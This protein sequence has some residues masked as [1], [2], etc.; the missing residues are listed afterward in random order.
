[1]T[2]DHLRP[3]VNALAG[4]YEAQ[5]RALAARLDL[6]ALRITTHAYGAQPHHA[7]DVIAPAAPTAPMPVVLFLHG[8][9]FTHGHR[10][11]NHFMAPAIRAAGAIL[12]SA[13][14]RLLEDGNP[15]PVPVDDV[16]TAIDWIRDNATSFGG[17]PARIFTGGHSAGAALAL[18]AA[19]RV[20]H[21]ALCGVLCLSGSLNRWAIT[22]TEGAGYALP[23][24]PL[25]CA[26]DAP[27]ALAAQVDTPVLFAW[28]DGERQRARVERSSM[29]MILALAERGIDTEW[30][31]VEGADH[32]QTHTALADPDHPLARRIAAWIARLS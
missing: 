20:P 8:G 32:F 12:V 27:L 31:L 11:W 10:I 30:M 29:A 13:S 2:D 19:T 9:G 7:L 4:A 24:G 5:V 18:A 21:G 1:M 25:P 22:G 3:A 26:P 28:G 15:G 14:Y 17:D 16:T 23:P 6:S